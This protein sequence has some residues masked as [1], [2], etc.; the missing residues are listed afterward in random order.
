MKRKRQRQNLFTADWLDTQLGE[1]PLRE[2]FRQTKEAYRDQR[3]LRFFDSLAQDLR[4]ALR[5]LANK[6]A[7]TAVRSCANNCRIRPFTSLSAD[8]RTSSVASTGA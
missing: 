3:S 1:N 5:M 8:A 2:L 6:P 4:F 7:F